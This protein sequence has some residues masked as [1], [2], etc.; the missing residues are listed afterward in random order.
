MALVV[1]FCVGFLLLLIGWNAEY[2]HGTE[3]AAVFGRFLVLV[4]VPVGSF[5]TVFSLRLLFF[6]K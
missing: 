5:L 6:K 2:P 3:L 4:S 1:L